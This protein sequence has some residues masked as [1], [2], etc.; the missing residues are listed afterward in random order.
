[1]FHY[2]GSINDAGHVGKCKSV[3]DAASVAVAQL[4]IFLFFWLLPA[5]ATRSE[6]YCTYVP[7]RLE[8]SRNEL[9]GKTVR[10]PH[11]N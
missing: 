5:P 10:G 11:R 2:R 7:F 6:N 9:I 8:G 4:Y 1:M 3:A